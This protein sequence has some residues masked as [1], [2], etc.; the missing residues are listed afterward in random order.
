MINFCNEIFT[1]SDHIRFI[2][3]KHHNITIKWILNKFNFNWN[4]N[5]NFRQKSIIQK[6]YVTF[7][8]YFF[9]FF[10]FFVFIFFN[11]IDIFVVIIFFSFSS[12]G[13]WSWNNVNTI[14]KKWR[15]NS[16]SIFVIQWIKKRNR[17]IYLFFASTIYDNSSHWCWNLTCEFERAGC[18]FADVK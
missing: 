3:D 12:T 7:S 2:Y 17:T 4:K 9:S 16:F 11:F 8:F 10:F 15:K 1:Q 5:L 6:N 14:T 18:I 13:K